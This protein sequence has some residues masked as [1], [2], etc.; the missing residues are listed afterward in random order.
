MNYLNKKLILSGVLVS[1]FMSFIAFIDPN[2]LNIL[3][4]KLLDWKFNLRGQ[5]AH[6]NNIVIVN[7]DDSSIS[8]LGR[9]PWKR[10]TFASVIDILDE[11]GV[12]VIAFDIYFDMDK[13][14]PLDNENVKLVNSVKNSGKVILPIYFNLN[15]DESL[16]Y[17]RLNAEKAAF[18]K[19]S[20]IEKL[21]AHPII[22]GYDLFLSYPQLNEVSY[23]SGHINVLPDKDGITRKEILV[24]EYKKNYFPA[25]G[26]KVV[27]KYFENE[28]NILELNGDEGI[29]VGKK[30]ISIEPIPMNKTMIWG[31]KYINYR[32]GYKTFP[33]YS[34]SDV[35]EHKFLKEDFLNKIVII[36]TTSAGL[37]DFIN[38]PFSN[39]FPGVE[40]QANIIDNILKEDFISKPFVS[41]FFIV[42]SCF[43]LGLL[44]T[45][46]ISRLNLF[47]QI[48]TL[49][50]FTIGFFIISY[51]AFTK[52]SV[53]VYT[54]YPILSIWI[55]A[56]ILHVGLYTQA[57]K[58]YILAKTENSNT[59]MT[60]SKTI[61]FLQK[62]LFINPILKNLLIVNND[63]I[64]IDSIK[65][66]LETNY[67]DIFTIFSATNGLDA[68][69]VLNNNAISIMIT[70]VNIK[71]N[72]E[73]LII[74]LAKN[75]SDISIIVGDSL[76]NVNVKNAVLQ[77]GI[78]EG[79]IENIS[80]IDVIARN[81]KEIF[82]KQSAGG[83]FN[84]N[85][86]EDFMQFIQTV[87]SSKKTCTI[88]ITNRQIWE[89]GALFFINGELINGRIKNLQGI[90][91]VNKIFLWENFSCSIENRC[92]FKQRI[93]KISNIQAI[94]MNALRLKD[95]ALKK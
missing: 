87:A 85:S 91:A 10:S 39:V 30:V 95:E 31:W 64:W 73:K 59:I 58:E 17:K 35:M 28:E 20:N 24:I 68:I 81:I 44:V 6:S 57:K 22:K 19:I 88:R 46:I 43:F 86:F 16:K 32:G 94:I 7:I 74:Y 52:Y 72:E 50:L 54:T 14:K 13:D 33:Y 2:V 49:I 29:K 48:I 37:Y 80:D 75:Y 83:I 66:G 84:D 69:K 9:W 93:I 90:E 60:F 3:E 38:T 65:K 55:V 56:M 34:F 21:K 51:I 45:F 27:Q 4:L 15:K 18:P 89:Y 23:G 82:Q 62:T 36:G 77:K 8:K 71:I 5:Q 47:I 61:E 26:F 11:S 53:W 63:Q 40:L 79:Y 25:F 78:A 70:D 92:K 42:V 12:K 76:A 41:D 1:L 67:K